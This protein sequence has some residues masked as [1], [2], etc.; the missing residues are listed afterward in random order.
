VETYELN[1]ANS[2][3]PWI[4]NWR[5]TVRSDPGLSFYHLAAVFVAVP[6]LRQ[7]LE[8]LPGEGVLPRP[9]SDSDALRDLYSFDA[10]PDLDALA[11]AQGVQPMENIDDLV[12]D[13]W[14][15]DESVENFIAAAMEGRYEEDEPD[16]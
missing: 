5:L 16:S 10:L 11:A 8:A 12:A 9:R 15:E 2:L 7:F 13:L 14:S 4:E 6:D 3:E 1:T